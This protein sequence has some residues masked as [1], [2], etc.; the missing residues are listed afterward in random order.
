M[1]FPK[2]THIKA[3][4]KSVAGVPS[5][6]NFPALEES[7]LAHWAETDMFKQSVDA[8]DAGRGGANEFVFYDG[9]PFANGLP[10]Y[11]HLLTGYAKDVIPRFQTML[12]RRVDRRFGWDTHGLPAE[13]SAQEDLGITNV[14]QIHELGIEKFNEACRKNVLKY[15][16]IWE[17]YVNRQARWVDFG[18]DYKTMNIEYMESVLWAF[19][20]LHNKGLAYKGYKVMPYCWQDETVLS[21]HELKMDDDVYKD[22]QDNTVTVAMKID[23]TEEVLKDAYVAV[24]TTTPWTLPTNFA[25]AVN[26][27]LDYC[28]VR[29]STN[30]DSPLAGKTVILGKG[31]IANYSKEVG[32]IGDPDSKDAPEI[33]QTFKGKDL[34]GVKYSPIFDYFPA[35]DDFADPNVKLSNAYQIH[36]A[37]Y[38]GEGEGTGLV[39][40]APYGEDDMVVLGELGVI[41]PVPMTTGAILTKEISDYEGL[42]VFEANKPIIA[43]LRSPFDAPTGSQTRIS[44][45]KRAILVR[46]QSVAHSYPHC[47]R[48]RQPLIYR[49]ISSWFLNVTALKPRMIELNENINWIPQNVQHGQFGAWLEGARDWA[50]SRNRFW[51]APIPVWTSDNDEFPCT[52]VYGSIEELEDA[53]SDCLQNNPDAKKAYPTGKIDNLHRPHIDTLTKP[54]PNDPTGKSKLVRI[55]DVFDCWFESG[56]MPFAQ[57]HYP[58]ENKVWFEEH[59]PSDFIVEYIGQTRGWF[60]KLHIMSTGLFDCNAFKNVIC[61][62]VVLGD[63]GQKMSK[64]LRNYPDVNEVFDKY[65]SDAMRWFLMSS[66]ILNG[67]NLIVTETG[68][69]DCVRNILLPLWSSYYFFCMYVNSSDSKEARLLEPRDLSKLNVQDRYILA[70][71]RNLVDALSSGLKDYKISETCEEVREFLDVLTNWYIRTQRE[72]FWKE[73]QNAFNTLWTVLEFF[74]R[75]VA[76]LL[77]LTAEE[78]WRGLTGGESVH[79]EVFPTVDLD[80]NV[81][82]TLVLDEDLALVVD[83]VRSIVGTT[84]SLRKVADMRVRQP[85]AELKVVV[86]NPEAVSDFTDVLKSE[87]N[88]KSVALLNS[89]DVKMEDYG[90]VQ[91]LNVNARAL[92]PRIGKRVQEVIRAS[93]EG[94]WHV[95]DGAPVVQLSDGPFALEGEEFTLETVL[96]DEVASD[97]AQIQAQMLP[98]GGFVVLDLTLTPDLI[99]EGLARDLIR[100]IQETRKNEGLEVTDRINLTLALTDGRAKAAHQFE[101]LIKSEVLATTFTVENATSDS[102]KL[103]TL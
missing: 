16:D 31:S 96:S 94:N 12:G 40:I 95:S 23:S 42:H 27:D 18:N 84:L 87:L 55:T 83:Q 103:S 64:S 58:F 62:G 61:H 92:G 14:E 45:D 78:I 70:K 37:D 81:S 93:K 8:H 47:W 41:P 44:Q 7:V 48:C 74:T 65:G 99:N 49:P 26:P 71:T 97:D 22:R 20:E 38:V 46:T 89:A 76:P 68:I 102:I 52:E 19:K 33:V 88:V 101:E 60:D 4:Q 9:P 2:T 36:T 10:H 34:K 66:N 43:D 73:D 57:V 63:D 32:P 53:F 25:V 11:G 91:K 77:P 82:E 72:R 15:T 21:N 3:E 5:S 51:G 100:E 59:F 67:G 13:L 85:L 56:S 98:Q 28:A 75:A 1:A 39:H 17:D 80:R 90:L 6:P 79:L 35:T 24:W 29:V 69:K 30:L 86:S 54:N 50:L